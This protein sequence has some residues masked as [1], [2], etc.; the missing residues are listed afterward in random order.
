M[1]N[2]TPIIDSNSIQIPIINGTLP[3]KAEFN[4]PIFILGRN[5]AGKSALA[6][7]I[8]EQLIKNANKTV[9]LPGSRPSYFAIE[10]PSMTPQSRKSFDDM[11]LYY[12]GLTAR[13][14]LPAGTDLNEKAIHDLVASE[15]NYLQDIKK[16]ASKDQDTLNIK[17]IM[18]DKPS[19]IDQINF[20]LNQAQI[21]VKIELDGASIISI[22]NNCKYSHAKMSDGERMALVFAAEVTAAKPGTFFVIDE[23]EL[24]L[25]S[26]I[27]IALISALITSRPDCVFIICTHELQLPQAVPNS[28]TLLVHNCTWQDDQVQEW[29]INLL[30]DSDEIPERLWNDVVGA[31]RT[32]LFVEGDKHQ[33]LDIGLYSAL[34][35]N[36]TI[37][38][39]RSCRDVI[40]A[41]RGLA[42]MSNKHR[43]K[44]MGIIDNDGMSL[45]TKNNFEKEGIFPL[46]V[47]SVESIIYSTECI[48]AM[49]EQQA[50]ALGGDK[51][52]L[53]TSAADKALDVFL[54]PETKENLASRLAERQLREKILFEIP[55]HKDLKERDNQVEIIFDNPYRTEL[56]KISE[57]IENR[58]LTDII[59][60]YPIR[61]S[62]IPSAIAKALEFRDKKQ[63]ESA[64]ITAIGKKPALQ[65]KIKQQLPELTSALNAL[66]N[67]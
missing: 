2:N 28:Q 46:P 31:R 45:E 37:S 67:P 12:T 48:E 63:Y 35:P 30:E 55:T 51:S 1:D 23:P 32:I 64:V 50:N 57:F 22:R 17:K 24:H 49:A 27:V 60:N 21:P 20:L 38:P 33:S 6:Q 56:N 9:Y 10:F 7:F 29:D 19:P 43:I 58:N 3:L 16:E 42:A 62:R 14:S 11:Q 52:E 18:Q 65:D 8:N 40:E 66:A 4:Q 41:V 5:G 26:S 25:H 44:A 53:L 36:I 34:F 54:S 47:Y 13:W 61:E 15:I 59:K 39:Q